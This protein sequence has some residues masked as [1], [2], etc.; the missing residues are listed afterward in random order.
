VQSFFNFVEAKASINAMVRHID[1]SSILLQGQSGEKL[2]KSM[3]N[4]H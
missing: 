2:P 1:L 4:S 3:A